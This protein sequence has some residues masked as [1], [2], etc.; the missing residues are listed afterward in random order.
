MDALQ[1]YFNLYW[2]GDLYKARRMGTTITF[3]NKRLRSHCCSAEVLRV[4]STPHLSPVKQ[5]KEDW[6]NHDS[7][8][9]EN[10]TKQKVYWAKQ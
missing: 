9:N 10:A 4:R 7:M 2:L 6:A 1:V 5:Q 3:Q 8:V